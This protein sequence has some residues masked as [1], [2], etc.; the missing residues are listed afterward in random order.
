MRT[1][2]SA[3]FALLLAAGMP[4]AAAENAFLSGDGKTI[5][6]APCSEEEAAECISH[7]ID[8]RGD[9]DLGGGIGIA[10]L[11][12]EEGGGPDARQL[13]RVLIGKPWGGAKVVADVGGVSVDLGVQSIT[14]S[15]N[16]MNG[17]WDLTLHSYGQTA[18]FDALTRE[19]A[20]GVTLDVAGYALTLSADTATA[21]KLMTFKQSCGR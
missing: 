7:T 2:A 11:G 1:A 17:D 9:G 20:A 5:A 14:V 18:L 16:E 10:I 12:A 21:D 3:A 13:A 6:Y 15:T 4:A 19:R 8:C